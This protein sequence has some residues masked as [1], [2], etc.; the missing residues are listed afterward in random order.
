[1]V[2]QAVEGGEALSSGTGMEVFDRYLQLA[3]E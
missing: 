2:T 3:M 1:V